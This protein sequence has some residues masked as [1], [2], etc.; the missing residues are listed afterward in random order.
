M[1]KKEVL[2]QVFNEITD[3][4]DKC[5]IVTGFDG[6]DSML[7]SNYKPHFITIGARPSMGKTSFAVSVLLNSLKDGKNCLVFS[8]NI[9]ETVYLRKLV[10]QIEGLSLFTLKKPQNKNDISKLKIRKALDKI[11]KYKLTIDDN[12]VDISDIKD[13]IESIKPDYV[14]I[15]D[16]NALADKMTSAN[17]KK[18]KQIALDNDCTIFA[19][20]GLSRAPENRKDKRPILSDLKNSKDMVNISDVIIFLYRNSY[21]YGPD[22][23]NKDENTEDAEII[24]AKNKHGAV[25]VTV[26]KFNRATTKFYEDC[27][28]PLDDDF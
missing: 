18:L 28:F 5:K 13:Q 15:D 10:A 24:L 17:L 23:Y 8:N 21:Y 2:D 27:K 9:S 20:S 7:E 26:T 14:F 6:L 19:L 1:I 22:P 16:I 11:S 12:Y 3:D 25:G 4:G